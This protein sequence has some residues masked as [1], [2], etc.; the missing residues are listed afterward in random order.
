MH[1]NISPDYASTYTEEYK[2]VCFTGLGN[3]SY[4]C[5]EFNFGCDPEAAK[6][7]LNGVQV[8]TTIFP[9][10][11]NIRKDAGQPWAS[12]FFKIYTYKPSM[13]ILDQKD[14]SFLVNSLHP[15]NDSIIIK[16][17]FPFYW[18]SVKEKQVTS[19]PNTRYRKTGS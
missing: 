19:T 14:L 5:A 4:V 3:T 7:V 11:I 17:W 8:P 16:C 6:L 12:I 1:F 2:L 9:W 15:T 10:E 18:W 13:S